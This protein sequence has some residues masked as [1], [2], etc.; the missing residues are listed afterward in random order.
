M[1]LAGGM[2]V[3]YY[4]GTRYTEDVDASFSR[5][6]LFSENEVVADYV[7]SDGK[8]SFI[9]LD[10]NYNPTFAL[11]HENFED[12]AL[13]WR[14]EVTT[15]LLN[16]KILSPVDLAVSKLSR[17][18]ERDREDIKALAMEGL[19]TDTALRERAEEALLDYVGNLVSVKNSIQIACE[20]V[21]RIRAQG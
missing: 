12:D 3:N 10:T 19:I 2:A 13:P 18:S 5:R 17:F 6:V 21:K 16:L 7:R 20:D 15:G 9:Y 1:Y 4:C 11:M 14:P 8:K